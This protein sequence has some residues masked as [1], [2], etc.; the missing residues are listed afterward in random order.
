MQ[1]PPSALVASNGHIKGM[2]GAEGEGKAKGASRKGATRSAS[3]PA[4]TYY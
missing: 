2:D 4:G 1:E 3:L